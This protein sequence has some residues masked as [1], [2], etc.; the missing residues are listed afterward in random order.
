MSSQLKKQIKEKRGLTEGLSAETLNKP[1]LLI[2]KLRKTHKEVWAVSWTY[3]LR[4][5]Y[6]SYVPASDGAPPLDLQDNRLEQIQITFANQIVTVRGCNL[7]PLMDSIAVL[8]LSTLR[9]VPADMLEIETPNPVIVSVDL[10]E[11]E[12]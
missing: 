8:Q 11:R 7:E 2:H 1:G 12:R 4:A 9:E 6:L 5:Q 3:F 10:E